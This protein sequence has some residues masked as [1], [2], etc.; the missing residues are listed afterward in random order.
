VRESSA[1]ILPAVPRASS[2]SV[3]RAGRRRYSR[4]FHQPARNNLRVRSGAG[5]ARSLDCGVR[6]LRERT[7]SLGM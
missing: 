4:R 7:S 2:P 5:N 1:G 3:R 6:S